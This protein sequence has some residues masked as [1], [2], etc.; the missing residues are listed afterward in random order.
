MEKDLMQ[1][2]EIAFAVFLAA[3]C[4]ALV[5]VAAVAAWVAIFSNAVPRRLAAFDVLD[6]LLNF[7]AALIRARPGAG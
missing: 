6:R 7:F 1:S 5:V 4:S 3:A 2:I